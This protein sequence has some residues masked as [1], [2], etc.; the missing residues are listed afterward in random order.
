MGSVTSKLESASGISRRTHGTPIVEQT[1]HSIHEMDVKAFNLILSAL[2]YLMSSEQQLMAGIIPHQ[3]QKGIFEK[4]SRES[5]DLVIRD[6][7]AIISRVKKSSSNNDFL[8]IISVFQVVKHVHM[9]KPSM[10]R[11]LEASDLGIRGKYNKMTELFYIT[12][13]HGLDT[14]VDG[15]R[16]DPTTKEKMPK[17]GTVFQLTSN[18]ILFLEQIMEYVDTLAMILTQDTSYNQTL[19]RL[20]RKISVSDRNPALVGLY[21]RKVLV[22]L[23]LTL[24]NKSD[25]Y[26]DQFLKAVFRLNNN[27]YIL[28]ALQRSGLLAIVSLAEPDCEANYNDMIR[29]QKMLYSQSFS[30]VLHYIWNA[31]TDIPNAALLAPGR[32]NEKYSR[33]IKDKFEVWNKDFKEICMTQ[34]MYSIPDVELRESLK[35]D[36]KEYVCPIYS[37]FYE[38][39]HHLPFSKNPEKYVKYT[40]AEVSS[41]IDSF[42]DAAA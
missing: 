24:V 29:E 22:Q 42:F 28:K 21:I 4:I 12:G 31:E 15:I 5:L 3:Y 2:Q 18:V 33:V 7:D 6:S 37:R 9:L 20:P 23:N 17:D 32:F 16:A 36:N 26:A 38:K 8:S 34:R 10:D 1:E 11:T 27:Q 30:R 25:Y 14:F 41:Q 19:L 39:Y 40:P 13:S 35:R